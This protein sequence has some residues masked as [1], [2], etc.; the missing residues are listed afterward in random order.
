LNMA[1][2]KDL[3]ILLP[4]DAYTFYFTYWAPETIYHA[5]D[6]VEVTFQPYVYT[7]N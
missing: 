3:Y 5:V 7:Q 2:K 4:F 1:Y 6:P